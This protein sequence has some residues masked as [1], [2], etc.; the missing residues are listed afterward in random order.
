MKDITEGSRPVKRSEINAAI[1]EATLAFERHGWHL[2]PKPRWDVTG[3]GLGDFNR[4]GLVLVNLA[5]LPEYCEKLMYARQNQTTVMHCHRKKQEDIICRAGTFAIHLADRDDQWQCRRNGGA[6]TVLLDGLKQSVES[7][8]TLYLRAGQR[9][10]LYPG[11][12]HEFWPVS[13]YAVIGEV[14]TANDD[15]N[16]NFFENPDVGRYEG[17]DEDVPP[18]VKLL[19]E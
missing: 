9:I 10:T 11:V 3:F 14:S 19:N 12:Y 2:P 18:L 15:Q 1:A 17:I 13:E 16:D 8:A 5:D 7:D 6:V 4:F